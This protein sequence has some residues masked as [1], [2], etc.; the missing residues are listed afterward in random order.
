MHRGIIRKTQEGSTL[1]ELVD[2]V[3]CEACSIK[4][5]C[6]MGETRE[7]VFK[8]DFESEAYKD[9]EMVE[10]EL[11]SSLAFSALFWAY[12]F[13][14]LVLFTGLVIMTN[15]LNEGLSG[16]IALAFLAIYYLMVYLNRKYFDK[17]FQL[18]INRYD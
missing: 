14:F 18:K 15:F 16:L 11:S 6:Q 9:G 13:P 1:V 10:V 2:G 4:G 3:E 12:I 8:V 5:S 17:K 7:N